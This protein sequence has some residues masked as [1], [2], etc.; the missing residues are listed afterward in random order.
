M[1]SSV[2]CHLLYHVIVH[3]RSILVARGV[4]WRT[5]SDCLCVCVCADVCV[6]MDICIQDLACLL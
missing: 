6:L 4:L 3:T 1:R 5:G 2:S